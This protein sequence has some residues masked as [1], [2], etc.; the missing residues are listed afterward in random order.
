MK[1]NLTEFEKLTAKQIAIEADNEKPSEQN[2][3]DAAR[4]TTK[5]NAKRIEKGLKPFE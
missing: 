3:I 5:C 1:A 4:I 2:I